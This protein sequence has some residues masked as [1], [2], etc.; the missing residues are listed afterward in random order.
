M[1]VAAVADPL[2]TGRQPALLYDRAT[3]YGIVRFDRKTRD[4]TLECWPRFADPNSLEGKPYPG[5]PI[6]SASSTTMAGGQGLAADAQV[7]GMSD[8]VVQV[9][10][11]KNDEIIYTV[12]AKGDSFRPRS[13]PRALTRSNAAT[14]G[15][16]PGRRCGMSP[17][18]RSAARAK[19]PSI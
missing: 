5:W 15:R 12:R 9:I 16:S 13:S 2:V 14:R 7:P 1:S 8:P 19:R 10:D 4:I 17:P 11:E 3:G 18:F 6:S